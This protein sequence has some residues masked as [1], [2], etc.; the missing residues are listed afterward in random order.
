MKTLVS[1]ILFVFSCGALAQFGDS[2]ELPPCSSPL[3]R[4]AKKPIPCKQSI[5]DI[6]VDFEIPVLKL[7]LKDIEKIFLGTESS[8][9][10]RI[11]VPNPDVQQQM[12]ELEHF[13]FEFQMQCKLFLLRD[14][15]LQ[16]SLLS[17]KKV[18]LHNR[19]Q[20]VSPSQSTWRHS[21]VRGND[22][23]FSEKYAIGSPIDFVN[24][25]VTLGV[26]SE[27]STIESG[28]GVRLFACL[29]NE[30][31]DDNCITVES[32]PVDAN[33]GSLI[34]RRKDSPENI[35]RLQVDCDLEIYEQ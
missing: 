22:F 34:E 5:G 23:I 24:P 25:E 33:I 14:F 9:G 12:P 13:D 21:I 11:R 30:N 26:S 10:G 6:N 18:T 31:G 1:L 29:L 4:F 20:Y 15:N 2:A 27:V 3:V 19:I 32:A 8:G 35:R 16:I 17:E 7:G 28:R